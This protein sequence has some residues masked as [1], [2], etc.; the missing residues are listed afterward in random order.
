MAA[1]VL[2]VVLS[3]GCAAG[4]DWDRDPVARWINQHSLVLIG[5]TGAVMLLSAE[6]ETADAGKRALDAAAGSAATSA[7]LKAMVDASRPREP[8]ADDGFPSAHTAVAFGFARALTD[9]QPDA[10][11]AFYGFASAVGWARVE[12][13][14]HDVDQVLAGA[15]LGLFVAD[16]SLDSGGLLLH[17]SDR[18]GR[19]PLAGEAD[20]GGG[21]RGLKWNLWST[22]W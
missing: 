14:Y 11:P 2:L 3:A 1:P 5:A 10:R 15:A 6:E 21:S 12:G 18:P 8:T 9:W 20:S 13:G 19:C 4:Q 22:V 7:V 17:S 16:R